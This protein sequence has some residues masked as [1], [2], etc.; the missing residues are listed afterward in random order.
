MRDPRNRKLWI[1]LSILLLLTPLG[2]VLP[3]KFNARGAWGEWSA[4]K[5]QLLTGYLPTGL[6]RLQGFWK[7]LFPDYSIP[8]LQKPWQGWLAYLAA[9]GI[10]T[11][12]VIVICF[13]LGKWLSR[14]GERE[15]NDAP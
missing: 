4:H 1:G 2:I 12:V 10:G 8:G 9:G 3:E 6:A 14:G 15:G 7:A 13:G 5:V 11:A